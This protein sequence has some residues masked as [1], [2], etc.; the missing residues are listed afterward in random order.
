LLGGW[1]GLILSSSI[2][3]AWTFGFSARALALKCSARAFH[4]G[5]GYSESRYMQMVWRLFTS[6]PKP[7]VN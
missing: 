2:E 7:A 5:F 3:F 6:F 1:F 4:L